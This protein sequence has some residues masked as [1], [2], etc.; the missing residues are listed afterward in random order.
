MYVYV[1]ID[2]SAMLGGMWM[3]DMAPRQGSNQ[4]SLV[5]PASVQVMSE[6]KEQASSFFF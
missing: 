3:I 4:R 5:W 2:V 1:L 6:E